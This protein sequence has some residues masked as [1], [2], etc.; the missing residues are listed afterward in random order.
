MGAEQS[1]NVV[2][3]TSDWGSAVGEAK[4]GSLAQDPEGGSAGRARE[5]WERGQAAILTF[6]R[7]ALDAGGRDNKTSLSEAANSGD[8]R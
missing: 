1:V 2:G 6:S 5:A 7:C 8:A 4:S 3:H